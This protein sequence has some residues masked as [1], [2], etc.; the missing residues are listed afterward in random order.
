MEK[1]LKI[2]ITWMNFL[3]EGFIYLCKPYI[4]MNL[5]YNAEKLH[6]YQTGLIHG[7]RNIFNL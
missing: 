1:M 3:R 4:G 2:A 7:V 6:K 5:S